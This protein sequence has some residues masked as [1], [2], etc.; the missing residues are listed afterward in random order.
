MSGSRYV[1]GHVGPGPDQ[2]QR[3]AAVALRRENAEARESILTAER[4]R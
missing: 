1:A 3:V 2:T 4:A